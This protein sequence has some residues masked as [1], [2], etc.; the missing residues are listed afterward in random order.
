[1]AARKTKLVQA[2]VKKEFI[3][4]EGG[5]PEYR[6][7]YVNHFQVS[8]HEADW[9]L[10]VGVL[11]IDDLLSRQPEIRF[12]VSQRLAMSLPTMKKLRD[13][14]TQVLEKAAEGAANVTAQTGGQNAKAARKPRSKANGHG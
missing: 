12:A 14:I 8:R 7:L 4:R 9:F 3:A 2:T 11:P 13:Q 1:M 6:P 10:D 5:T